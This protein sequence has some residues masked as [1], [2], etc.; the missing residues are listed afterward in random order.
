MR[1]LEQFWRQLWKE[2]RSLA[3]IGCIVC[4]NCL[5]VVSSIGL[6]TYTYVSTR[7]M[8]ARVPTVQQNQQIVQTQA[9]QPSELTVDSQPSSA[10]QER[11]DEAMNQISENEQSAQTQIAVIDGKININTASLELL[12][13]LTGIGPQKAQAIIDYRQ[14]TPFTTIEDIMKVSGIGEKTFEK[15]QAMI[16][17][18]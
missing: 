11:S 8:V 10:D 2:N 6:T 13:E 17:V 3:V 4:V 15:I 16:I 1:F 12:M 14:H 9:E 7:Q 18:Q 5:L